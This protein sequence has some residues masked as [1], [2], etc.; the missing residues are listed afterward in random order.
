MLYNVAVVGA[1]GAVGREMVKVLIERKFPIKD[2]VLLASERSAGETIT[3]NK[4]ELEV[5]ELNTSSFKDIDIA[6]FSVGGSVSKKF[7]P[8]AVKNGTIV[9]DNSSA[10]RMD[11]HVPLIV[12]EVNPGDVKKH[13]GIIANPNCSTIQMVV[14]LKPILDE[15]GIKRIIV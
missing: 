9:I 2:L 6:L 1:T 5:Q 15:V 3:F 12:P 10:F 13:S 4:E 7:V 14:A 8:I 11:S